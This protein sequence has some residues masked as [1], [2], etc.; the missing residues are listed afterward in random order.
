MEATTLHVSVRYRIK[1]LFHIDN[2]L[3]FLLIICTNYVNFIYTLYKLF[4]WFDDQQLILCFHIHK[5]ISTDIHYI[6]KY[7]NTGTRIF[8]KAW[9]YIGIRNAVMSYVYKTGKLVKYLSNGHGLIWGW[10]VG[11]KKQYNELHIGV[12]KHYAT[13]VE[14][15]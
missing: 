9:F 6:I 14:W 12:N 10:K 2:F 11:D 15:I 13:N 8:R 1:L 3:Y 7:E 5:P 4:T